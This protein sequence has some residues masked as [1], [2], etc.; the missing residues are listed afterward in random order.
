[1]AAFWRRQDMISDDRI[2][3]IS[4]ASARLLVPSPCG[5]QLIMAG[6]VLVKKPINISVPEAASMVAAAEAST[7][8]TAAC[9]NWRSD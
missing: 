6:H 7:A 8:V 5:S 1:M 9:F 3:M 4:I 2:D